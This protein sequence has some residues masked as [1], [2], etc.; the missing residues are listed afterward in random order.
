VSAE[1]K[2]RRR[3]A[4]LPVE[5]D[6][7]AAVAGFLKTALEKG[8]V[9]A[10]LLPMEVPSGDSYAWIL[11]KDPALV[12]D[13]RAMA[14]VMPVQGARALRSLTRK[15]EGSL[16]VLALMR[17][18]E[19]RAARELAKLGQVKTGNLILATWDCPG[20]LPMKD[21]LRDPAGGKESFAGML[22]RGEPLDGG[23]KPSCL[24]CIDF[25]MTDADLHF[26]NFLSAGGHI[27]VLAGSPEG[28]RLLQADSLGLETGVDI[29]GWEPCI[30]AKR[31]TRMAARQA[32]FE[33]TGGKVRGF[34]GMLTVFADCIGCRNCRAACPI[35]YC[36]LCYFDSETAKPDPG[37]FLDAA[38]VRGGV[39][40]PANRLLFHI[41][42]MT[43]MSLSCVSCG[44]CSDACPADI[45]VADV[46][47]L[48]GHGT[49]EAFEY[50]AGRND[51]V[52]LPLRTFLKTELA[53]IRELVRDAE[54]GGHS[55]E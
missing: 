6:L 28:Q 4:M 55:L 44:Q 19:V 33:E 13:A 48:V 8:V 49:R 42:R 16:R 22:A 53:G 38:A 43:H 10:V 5:G 3:S 51:G 40:L 15:G 46:F 34:E 39:S 41:G 54:P 30:A 27:P 17:P 1:V 29:E 18:C 14:P 35:C 45:P 25:S 37:A 21:F 20:A 7:N 36:R 31:E 12:D 9:D 32:A 23:V 26:C 11:M 47:S 50:V 24:S 2:I 52:P